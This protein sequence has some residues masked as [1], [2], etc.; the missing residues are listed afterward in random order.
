MDLY[1][2]LVRAG[3]VE[4]H[5]IVNSE[6]GVP[7]GGPL[8]PLLSN[9]F[10]HDFDVFMERYI[11]EHSSNKK[12]ISKVN[13]KIVNYSKKLTALH[14]RY[15]ENR[16]LNILKEIRQLRIERNTLPSRIR[17]GNR[18]SYIRYADD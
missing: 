8:S 18:V 4:D 7:Q 16:D 14:R 6:L 12:F 17:T 1:W 2:K 10:L 3:Y 11:E 5:K 9:I 15:I 13:P